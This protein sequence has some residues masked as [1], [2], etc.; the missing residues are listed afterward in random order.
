MRRER[1]PAPK[2]GSGSERL[3][4]DVADMSDEDIEAL[5]EALLDWYD[6]EYAKAQRARRRR[7]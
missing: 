6:R 3:V 2:R 4:V 5:A 7:Q 1:L